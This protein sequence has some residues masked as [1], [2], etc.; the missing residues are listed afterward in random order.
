MEKNEIVLK[1][2]F[3]WNEKEKWQWTINLFLG[4]TLLFSTRNSMAVCVP[5]ITKELS[6]NKEISGMALSSFFFGYLGSNIFGGH[7]AD[8]FGGAK[9]IMY[10]S[11]VWSTLTLILPLFVNSTINFYSPN[12][13]IFALRFLTGCSQGFFFPSFIALISNSVRVEEKGFVVGIC[14]SGCAIGIILTGFFGSILIE[15]NHWPF[16]FIITG[17]SSL[18]W[19]IWFRSLYTTTISNSKD[20]T[21]KLSGNQMGLLE[22]LRKILGY[23]SVWAIFISY[24]GS[25]ATYSVLNS[26]T[27]VYFHDMFPNSKGWIFNVIPWLTSFIFELITGYYANRMLKIGKSP[28]F[29]RKSFA[30][31]LFIGTAFFSILLTRISNFEQALLLMSLIAGFSAFGSSSLSLNPQDVC[32]N[33][34]GSLFGLANAVGSIGGTVGIYLTGLVLEK[35]NDNWS[36]VFFCNAFMS[37]CSCFVFLVFGSTKPIL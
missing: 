6:W 11:V 34:S 22:F 33:H 31:V 9:M 24:L 17:L 8:K 36:K 13:D 10:S 28:L 32:P 19:L 5:A 30:A 1:T 35:G 26:W 4:C 37:L 21:D 14:Y 3:Y 18:I 25:G 2:K 23:S 29:V 15:A 16:V 27:P 12:F 20:V 7:F